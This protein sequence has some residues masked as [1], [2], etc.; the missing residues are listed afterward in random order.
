MSMDPYIASATTC[1]RVLVD[2]ADRVPAVGADRVQPRVHEDDVGG[3]EAG[4]IAVVEADRV[5]TVGVDERV[6]PGRDVGDGLVPA[7][8]DIGVADATHRIQDPPRMLDELVRRSALGAEVLPGVGVLLVGG[9]L[10]DPIVLNRHFHTT[11]GQAVPAEGV[12]RLRVETTTAGHPTESVKPSNRSLGSAIT[13][14]SWPSIRRDG[15]AVRHGCRAR[16]SCP[17]PSPG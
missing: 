13:P 16:R 9:D 6:H 15:P 2:R 10:G 17:P 3:R 7:G 4:R 5:G 1:H 8:L 11:R 12:H 14:E